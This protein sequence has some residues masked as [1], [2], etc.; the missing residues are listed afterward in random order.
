MAFALYLLQSPISL[1]VSDFSRRSVSCE[2][3]KMEYLSFLPP[4][5]S[6]HPLPVVLLLHGAGD[7]AINFIRPWEKIAK[8]EKIALIAPQ[9]PR[10]LSFEASAPKVFR[11]LVDDVKKLA[12]LDPQR[13]YL[14]GN[15]MGGYL[16]YD[17]ALLESEY[18]AAAAVHAMG[19]DDDYVGII[20]RAKRKIPIAIFTGD[21]DELVSLKQV[22]KTRDLLEKAGFPMH[23][24]EIPKHGH[25]YYEISDPINRE[26]WEFL[27][28]YRLP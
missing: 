9:L 14:F 19:I 23:Y 24:R 17:G 28:A 27:S 11:C 13:I 2:G 4:S 1:A 12:A 3:R 5:W 10:E 6:D 26:A 20:S 25:N 8:Q 7:E 15:S 21:R 18:F 16:T 22:K